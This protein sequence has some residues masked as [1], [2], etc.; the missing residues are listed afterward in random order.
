LTGSFNCR[1]LGGELRGVQF[2]A[3]AGAGC[4]IFP[5]GKLVIVV[6]VEDQD[7][8]LAISFPKSIGSEHTWKEMR[9]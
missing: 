5:G 4:V 3:F 2:V 7:D 1:V 9:S 6:I 8:I